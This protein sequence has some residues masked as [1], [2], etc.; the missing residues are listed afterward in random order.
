MYL[1]STCSGSHT[2]SLR[3]QLRG[4]EGEW[5]DQIRYLFIYLFILGTTIIN[6]FI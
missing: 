6:S 5:D 2:V 1:A 4:G 3:Y